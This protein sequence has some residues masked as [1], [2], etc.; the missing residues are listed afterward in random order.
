MATG[1]GAA[2]VPSPRKAVRDRK[3]LV[4]VVSAVAVG[5]GI[6]LTAATAAVVGAQ[7]DKRSAISS[8]SAFDRCKQDVSWAVDQMVDHPDTGTQVVSERWGTDDPRTKASLIFA[9]GFANERSTNGQDS[10][11]RLILSGIE[12]WC[13]SNS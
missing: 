3:Q 2:A 12:E 13:G 10:A 8:S 1:S 7:H 9:L 6:L 11:V 5:A 4:W